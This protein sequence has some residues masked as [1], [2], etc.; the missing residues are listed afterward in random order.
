MDPQACSVFSLCGYLDAHT[1]RP[2]LPGTA[3]SL[4]HAPKVGEL[5]PHP[6]A[7]REPSQSEGAHWALSF[8]HVNIIKQ[9]VDTVPTPEA[10]RLI[11]EILN[12]SNPHCFQA[13]K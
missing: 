5:L 2:G 6:N 8:P 12:A 10:L 9:V 4:G 11:P 3:R 1:W 13:Q 7:A